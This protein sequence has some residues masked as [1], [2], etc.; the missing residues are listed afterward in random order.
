L[1]IAPGDPEALFHL[2]NAA[3]ERGDNQAAIA[4]FSAALERAPGHYG[5]SNNLGLAYK[6]ARKLP[7]AEDAFRVALAANPGGLEPLANLAQN[8]YQQ[9]R[10]EDA[11]AYFDP[12]LKQYPDIPQAAI[13]ANHG[14]ALSMCGRLA[15]AEKSLARALALEPDP[16][17]SS[18]TWDCCTSSAALGRRVRSAGKS[19]AKPRR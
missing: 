17:A 15:E 1:A 5:L 4:H 12:L 18:A 14:V 10:Y 11:L 6:N 9:Q 16:P 3:R 13:H 2:G 19:R 7:E 8:L